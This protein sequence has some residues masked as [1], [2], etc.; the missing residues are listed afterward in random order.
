MSS[1][2]RARRRVL[3]FAAIVVLLALLFELAVR[4]ILPPRSFEAWRSASLRYEFHPDYHWALAPGEYPA[5]AG[6]IRVNALGLRDAG[7]IRPE[8]VAGELRIVVLGGSST[9]NYHAGPPGAWPARLEQRLAD[10]LAR[11]VRVI[12]AGTPGYSTLQSARR[13]ESQ[14]I[15][16]EPDVV[17]VYHLWNDLKT[18]GIEDVD[19]VIEKWVDQGR[20]NGDAAALRPSSFWDF[21]SAHSQ[22]ITHARFAKIEIGKRLRQSSGEGFRHSALDR[23]VTETGVAFFR[24][25]L[26][27]MADLCANRGIDLV[28]VDQILLPSSNNSEQERAKIQ[29][30]FV[31]FTPERLW[32]AILRAR[33]VMYEIAASRPHVRLIETHTISPSAEHLVDHV[34]FTDRGLEALSSL[35][36]DEVGKIVLATP[37]ARD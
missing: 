18:F 32:R 8:K 20:R 3:F 16:L 1:E 11:P 15:Q 19:E 29:Y 34:H 6:V 21:M 17:L 27:Q 7:E 5:E 36:A 22:A 24:T 9:F 33:A 37:R 35:L 2:V 4:I 14:L 30:E 12:N 26:Q 31:G 25:N 13:L 23:E 10:R 28:L